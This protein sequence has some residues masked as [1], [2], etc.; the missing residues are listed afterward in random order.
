MAGVFS[1]YN[2]VYQ[3]VDVFKYVVYLT[4]TTTLKNNETRTLEH[5]LDRQH[6]RNHKI[7]TVQSSQ[8]FAYCCTTTAHSMT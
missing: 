4:L 6:R 7:I 1:I 2:C 3:A 5:R 8:A